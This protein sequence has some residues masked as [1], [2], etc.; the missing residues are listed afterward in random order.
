MGQKKYC[1]A[2]ICKDDVLDCFAG[3]ECYEEVKAK[4][5]KMNDHKMKVLAD[6]LH[7]DCCNQL[8]WASL[9]IIFEDEFL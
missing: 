3:K 6:K 1:V 4:L 9:R 5:E 2:S 7:D 8:F